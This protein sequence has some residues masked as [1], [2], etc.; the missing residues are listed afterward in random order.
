MKNKNS[1]NTSSSASAKVTRALNQ[2][3]NVE[4]LIRSLPKRIWKKKKTKL[5]HL[6]LEIEEITEKTK[7]EL[8][9]EL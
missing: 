9:D 3:E 7:T 4:S 5:N 1:S 8:A 6:L 2:L